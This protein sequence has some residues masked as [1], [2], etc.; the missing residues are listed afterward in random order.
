MFKGHSVNSINEKGRLSIPSKYR[1]VLEEC[2]ADR[3]ILTKWLDKCLVG[4]APDEWEKIEK[5]A[6]NLSVV[7]SRSNIFKR[8][9][10]GSAEEC[11]I[12]SQGRILIPANLREYAG[13]KKKCL[14]VGISDRLE[15]WDVETYDSI[16]EEALKDSEGLREGLAELG[17]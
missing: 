17:L 11:V 12:D 8:H 16:M 6:A 10:V 7:N 13:L 15:I 4:F 5:K 9:V 14:F 3:L 2:G 1:D